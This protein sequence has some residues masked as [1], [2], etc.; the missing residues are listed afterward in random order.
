MAGATIRSIGDDHIIVG[1]DNDYDRLDIGETVARVTLSSSFNH[2]L[3]VEIINWSSR[4]KPK[5]ARV[6]AEGILKLAETLLAQQYIAEHK[7]RRWRMRRNVCI[8]RAM[9][10]AALIPHLVFVAEGNDEYSVSHPDL[11]N[12]WDVSN[13][14]PGKALE[15]I[16]AIAA[17]LG[18]LQG[19]DDHP[20]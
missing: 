15:T 18:I 11:N 7:A 13:A 17:K 5:S 10:I 19:D 16:Q 3:D 2:P 14:L 1:L 9:K 12:S 4:K 8:L 6:S 20:F